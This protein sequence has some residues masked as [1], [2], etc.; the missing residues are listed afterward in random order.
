VNI[1]SL[2]AFDN[3][4]E[5][6]QSE[7]TLIQTR[8]NQNWITAPQEEEEEEEEEEI[9]AVCLLAASQARNHFYK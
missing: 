9:L 4:L 1:D 8:C 6:W 7:P 3:T 2:G 5:S